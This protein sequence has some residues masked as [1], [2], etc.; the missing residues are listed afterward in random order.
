MEFNLTSV[1]DMTKQLSKVKDNYIQ[2]QD[3]CKS[4]GAL[5]VEIATKARKLQEIK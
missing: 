3:K 5:K 4:I 2:M 1:T